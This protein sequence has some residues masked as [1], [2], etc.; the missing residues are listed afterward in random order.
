MLLF[1]RFTY[2]E[3]G[4]LDRTHLHFY[5]RKSARALLKQNGLEMVW[6]K[7][8]VMP[9]ELALGLGPRNPVLRAL[10]IVVGVATRLL[11]G[12]FGYQFVF[13]CRPGRL[14]ANHNRI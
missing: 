5:T 4:I 7:P 2:T 3:R 12:L 13:C 1:G 6:E 11:P 14:T 10:Q 8:T 9:V